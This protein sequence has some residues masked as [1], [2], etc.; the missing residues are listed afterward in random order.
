MIEFYANLQAAV[1]ETVHTYPIIAASKASTI[2]LTASAR[3]WL[4]Q[5]VVTIR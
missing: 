2:T 4:V 1:N 5:Q 3:H